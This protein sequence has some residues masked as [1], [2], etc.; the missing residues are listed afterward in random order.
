MN[1]LNDLIETLYRD[2]LTD[3]MTHGHAAGPSDCTQDP[4]AHDTQTERIRRVLVE[5]GELLSQ[6]DQPRL[7]EEAPS[8]EICQRILRHWEQFSSSAQGIRDHISSL[9]SDISR[10]QPWGDFDVMKLDELTQ[11]GIYIRFRKFPINRMTELQAPEQGLIDLHIRIVSQDA[12]WVYFVSIGNSDE[13]TTPYEAEPVEICPCP[14]STL[15]MLQTR[16][17]D[18]LRALET[19]RGDY[20]LAHYGEMYA[21]LREALPAGSPLPQLQTPHRG[22]R[23]RLRQMLGKL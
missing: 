7:D 12:D 11:G 15:I 18:S 21:A 10:M 5:M 23:Q 3:S 8:A 2:S 6:D 19:L 22:L 13:Q 17:K 14:I 9:E 4:S 16:D 20:A 1:I